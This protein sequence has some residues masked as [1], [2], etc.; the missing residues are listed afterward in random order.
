MK[1]AKL[2]INNIL[3]PTFTV[4]FFLVGLLAAFISAL[5]EYSVFEQL[6]NSVFLQMLPAGIVAFALI[7]SF[8]Y[9]KIYLHYLLNRLK[10]SGNEIYM[11]KYR[12]LHIVK[13]L[14][15]TISLSCS[16]MYSVSALYLSS[17]NESEVESQIEAINT[18]LS[19]SIEQIKSEE[20]QNYNDRILPYSENVTVASE[21]LN[22]FNPDGLYYWQA[23]MQ[24][25]SLKDNLSAAESTY[26]E[27]RIQFE[28]ERDTAI[29][30]KISE[31]TNTATEKIALLSDTT[32]S[33]VAAQYDNPILS[34]FLSV[35]AITFTGSAV[36]SR[37]TY[38]ILSV[39]IGLCVSVVLEI[40]ISFAFS[41][42][43]NANGIS[44][45]DPVTVDSKFQQ[46]SEQLILSFIKAFFAL[47]IYVIIVGLANNNGFVPADQFWVA[48]LAYL[49][50]IC[51][52]KFFSSK[53][54]KEESGHANNSIQMDFFKATKESIIQGVLSFA[55]FMLLGFVFGK[56]AI[57]LDISTI[58]IG[59]GA[60]LSS[61][62]GKLP[63]KILETIPAIK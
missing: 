56:E 24:L 44:F 39:I 20:N 26:E 3:I 47:T 28:Q 50:A 51:M 53:S 14:L 2:L 29:Q 12:W 48:L 55:G 1:F 52:T 9:T 25:Q 31:I 8:E 35:I 7:L 11:Q 37:F 62:L 30:T 38:L 41:L 57:A 49:I 27:K 16:I 33:S 22:N 17:Y 23:N 54:P 63:E 4:L 42:L 5:I 6:Y 59:L 32:S 36:Y 10:I 15:V 45:S 21:A 58:A 19:K 46:W 43:A 40:V 34:Q 60:T 13:Y 61:L 18:K